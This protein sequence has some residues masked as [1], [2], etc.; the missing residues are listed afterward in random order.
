[1]VDGLGFQKTV[2]KQLHFIL[3]VKILL[4]IHSNRRVSQ[5]NLGFVDGKTKKNS[6]YM[7]V[8]TIYWEEFMRMRIMIG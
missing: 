5:E 7:N 6:C 8:S 4:D 3:V 1:M 2:K